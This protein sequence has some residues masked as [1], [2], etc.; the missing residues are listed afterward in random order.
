LALAASSDELYKRCRALSFKLLDTT[1]WPDPIR[2]HTTMERV[3]PLPESTD[4]FISSRKL[5]QLRSSPML[6][7]FARIVFAHPLQTNPS[8]TSPVA[9]TS[10]R[11]FLLAHFCFFYIAGG[12]DM[13]VARGARV[14]ALFRGRHD[15]RRKRRLCFPGL[16]ILTDYLESGFHFEDGETLAIVIFRGRAGGGIVGLSAFSEF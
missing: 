4:G 6:A 3:L 11:R 13:R 14:L 15:E 5:L 12:G 8:P 10:E 9:R 7:L 16:L 2:P 1:S